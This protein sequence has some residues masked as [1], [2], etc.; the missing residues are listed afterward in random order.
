MTL[1]S[2]FDVSL[3]NV[4]IFVVGITNHINETELRAIASDPD[5][6]HF[7]N[8]TSINNLEFIRNN[9]LKHVCHQA[10]Q[11]S[12]PKSNRYKRK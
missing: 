12:S 4:R 10:S 2:H 7:F 6:D 3:Q 8:S 1:F 5:R 11:S 9:L